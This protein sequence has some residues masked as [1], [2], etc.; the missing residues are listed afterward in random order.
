MK[1]RPVMEQR[2]REILAFIESKLE[3]MADLGLREIGAKFDIDF[4]Y[5]STL[6]AELEAEGWIR[7]EPGRK[8]IRVLKA[9]DGTPTVFKVAVIK[10]REAET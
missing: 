7:R 4:S 2:K 1:P 9:S 5:V 6:L 3:A 10:H 8:G